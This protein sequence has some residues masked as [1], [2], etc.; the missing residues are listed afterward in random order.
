LY[1]GRYLAIARYLKAQDTVV[2]Y[3]KREGRKKGIM[4]WEW[5]RRPRI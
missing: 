1:G 3:M 4:N 2:S 5:I